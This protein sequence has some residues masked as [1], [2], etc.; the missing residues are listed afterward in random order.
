MSVIF[1]PF[2]QRSKAA[3]H[4]KSFVAEPMLISADPVNGRSGE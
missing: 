4:E 2:V 1:Y 3:D